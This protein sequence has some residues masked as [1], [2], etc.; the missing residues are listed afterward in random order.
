MVNYV[1]SFKSVDCSDVPKGDI[2]T[3][4]YYIDVRLT[5]TTPQLHAVNPDRFY[6]SYIQLTFVFDG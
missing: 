5:D 6:N 4:L 2:L 1:V 3:E